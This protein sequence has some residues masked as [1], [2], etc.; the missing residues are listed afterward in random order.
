MAPTAAL[1]TAFALI[2][3]DER[4]PGANHFLS[5]PYPRPSDG[6]EELK[7]AAVN[8]F[9][10]G[11]LPLKGDVRPWIAVSLSRFWPP[12]R[13]TADYVVAVESTEPVVPTEPVVSTGSV[14][15]KKSEE[16]PARSTIDPSW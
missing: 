1:T 8:Y 10:E 9:W 14:T 16:E 4:T 5:V 2:D 11:T 3:P 15:A 12:E 6:G 7:V 13:S